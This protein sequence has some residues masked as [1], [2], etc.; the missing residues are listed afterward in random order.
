MIKAET[1][2]VINRPVEKVFEFVNASENAPQWRSG[3]LESW[4]TSEGP[5]GVGTTL[6]EVIRFLG[7]RIESTF[8]VMEYEPNRKISAKTT[9][10]P[11]SFEVSRT[12]ESVEGGTRL[13]VTIEGE[14]GGFFKL[15]EP[16]VARMTNRQIETDHANLKDLLEA[17]A[18][19]SV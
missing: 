18:E 4:Q 13:T 9:S 12:F 17:Q 11:I 1:S 19:G 6:T 3:V 2:V 5:I 7:R 14:T 8:E 15:A 16:L 10:G